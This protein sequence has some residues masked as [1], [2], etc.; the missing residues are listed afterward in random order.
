M[1]VSRTHCSIPPILAKRCVVRD[2]SKSSRHIRED[3]N[4]LPTPY[5]CVEQRTWHTP[6]VCDIEMDRL[7]RRLH[8]LASPMGVISAGVVLRLAAFAFTAIPEVLAKRPELAPP[9]TSFRSC[10]SRPHKAMAGA[11]QLLVKEGIFIYANGSNP[12][13]GGVFYHVRYCT[14]SQSYGLSSTSHSHRCT[15]SSSLASFPPHLI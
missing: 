11:H 14:K 7:S 3:I 1:N 13:D 12:Y 10:R 5:I 2:A 6:Y 8:T 4:Q 9:T 15:S